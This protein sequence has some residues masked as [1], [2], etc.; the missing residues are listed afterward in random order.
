M[1]ILEIDEGC[2]YFRLL[3]GD[4][5]IIESYFMRMSS[6]NGI[7]IIRTDDCVYEI[8]RHNVIMKRKTVN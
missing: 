7:Y 3:D 4:K 5:V 1:N 2:T 8:P 6:S